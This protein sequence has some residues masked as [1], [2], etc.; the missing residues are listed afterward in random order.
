M[1]GLTCKDFTAISNISHLTSVWSPI[2]NNTI[3]IAL[4]NNFS[5]YSAFKNTFSSYSVFYFQV[6]NL[7]LSQLVLFFVFGFFFPV[8]V[9]SSNIL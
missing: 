7:F 5:S 9:S 4:K 8:I 3:L 6:I 1:F 2:N